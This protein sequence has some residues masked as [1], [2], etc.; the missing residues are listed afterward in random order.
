MFKVMDDIQIDELFNSQVM[1]RIGCHD[2][3]TV[4]VV[5]I[6]Y[7][8]D[9]NSIYAHSFEGMKISIMRKN[10]SVCFQV[11]NTKDLS[12]WSSAIG[13]GTFEEISNEEERL[14]A[15]R[16]LNSRRLP[17]VTSETM[18]LNNFWPFL[19]MEESTGGIFFKIVLHK[20]TGR[21]EQ[22][23]DRYFFAT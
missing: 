20:K 1:G 19:E 12:H 5:P 10:P 14:Y 4:Y 13:W 22:S 7:V 21:Y 17:L 8:F 11:D 23:G 9:G 16:Q 3:E 18:H 15:F 2:G 6:S